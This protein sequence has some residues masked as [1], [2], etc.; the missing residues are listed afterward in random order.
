ML[1]AAGVGAALGGG[2]AF[3]A[4]LGWSFGEAFDCALDLAKT[5][6]CTALATFAEVADAMSGQGDGI[7]HRT[8][9]QF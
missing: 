7:G 5:F 1:L 9:L 4:A 8:S 6:G 3:G 2:G